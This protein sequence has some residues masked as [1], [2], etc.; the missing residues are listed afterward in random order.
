[1]SCHMRK[2][3]IPETIPMYQ[4]RVR[5][6]RLYDCTAKYCQVV[7]GSGCGIPAAPLHAG[8]GLGVADAALWGRRLAGAPDAI[9]VFPSSGSL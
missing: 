4:S 3:L 9:E 7:L 1:M 6:V 5:W 8:A 2:L